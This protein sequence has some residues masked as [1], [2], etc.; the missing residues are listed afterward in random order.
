MTFLDLPTRIPLPAKITVQVLPPIDLDDIDGQPA[1]D[2]VTGVMQDALSELD[3]E[4]TVPILRLERGAEDRGEVVVGRLAR[5]DGEQARLLAR[6]LDELR[7][8]VLAVAEGARCSPAR[9]RRA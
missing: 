5:R 9:R 2:H 6:A 7:D 8:V 1:Y 3:A 4:R